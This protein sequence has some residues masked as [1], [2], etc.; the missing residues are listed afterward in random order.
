MNVNKSQASFGGDINYLKLDNGD[1]CTTLQRFQTTLKCTDFN[2]ANCM[3]CKLY[4]CK[5][6]RK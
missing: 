2:Q 4:L 1:D 3:V 6:V 5:A